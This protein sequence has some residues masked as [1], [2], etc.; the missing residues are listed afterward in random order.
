MPDVIIGMD[1][2]TKGDM[3]FI[4]CPQGYVFSFIVPSLLD[5]TDFN[6]LIQRYNDDLS[7]KQKNTSA[8]ADYRAQLK[9]RKNR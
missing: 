7:W 5:P 6:T 3:T 9:A 1:I 4:C 2:I 8:Q